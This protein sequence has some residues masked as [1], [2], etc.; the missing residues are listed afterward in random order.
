[1]LTTAN[2]KQVEMAAAAVDTLNN[3]YCPSLSPS[4]SPHLDDDNESVFSAHSTASSMSSIPEDEQAPFQVTDP[5]SGVPIMVYSSLAQAALYSSIAVQ[6][7]QRR[8]QTSLQTVTQAVMP[9]VTHEEVGGN[10]N[11][12]D[13]DAYFSMG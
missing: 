5:G 12:D 9:H 7:A 3:P 10:D 11:D 6:S 4:S 2:L 1:M 8:Q 13:E